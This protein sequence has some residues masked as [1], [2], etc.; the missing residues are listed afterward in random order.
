[1]SHS[2]FHK[3]NCSCVYLLLLGASL[4][5]QA[6][7]VVALEKVI[8]E[9]TSI[10][11]NSA[12]DAIEGHL[13]KA[14]AVNNDE[15]LVRHLLIWINVHTLF[16]FSSNE[17]PSVKYFS[18]SQMQEAAFK[19]NYSKTL[20]QKTYKI[21]GLYN[22]E[23]RAIYLLD[24]IDL[25]SETG[26]GVLLHELVHFLQYKYGYDKEVACI[27]KLESLAYLLEAKYL[28]DNDQARLRHHSNIRQQN[29]CSSS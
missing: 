19:K 24:N 23:E 18:A 2:I 27:N 16:A 25:H 8:D 21:L 5:L 12:A 28:T 15:A 10:S 13:Y 17:V 7:Q 29:S 14:P 1:M 4:C 9:V 26:K 3:S 11:T 6:N 22:F 20:E